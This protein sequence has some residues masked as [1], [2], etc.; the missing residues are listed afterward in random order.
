MQNPVTKIKMP[1]Q[2]L[3]TG[4]TIEVSPI[5]SAVEKAALEIRALKEDAFEDICDLYG[6]PKGLPDSLKMATLLKIREISNG[7]DC[8]V[9]F[10]C[11]H[12][13]RPSESMVL[14][15]NL[16][17]FSNF[18]K[19]QRFR[20]AKLSPEVVTGETKLGK[21]L[22]TPM[23]GALRYFE[24]KPDL[25]TLMDV[26]DLYQSLV[27]RFPKVKTSLCARCPLCMGFKEFKLTKG[28]CLE[29]LSE[30]SISSMYKTYHALVI[31]GFTKLDVDSMLPFEREVQ[32]GLIDKTIEER[33]KAREKKSL[34]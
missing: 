34:N 7:A 20:D 12:C 29:A 23:T 31:N 26:K 9:K 16:L 21:I 2:I 33:K 28:F 32:K 19:V 8:Q 24:D 27:F 11:P 6:V 18:E 1:F 22:E 13:H 15:E 5:S 10:K 4:E 25:K 3:A 14:L 30:H 17:D